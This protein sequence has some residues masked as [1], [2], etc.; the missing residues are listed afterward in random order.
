MRRSDIWTLLALAAM[1]GASFMFMRVVAPVLGWA[2]AANTRVMLGA[3]LI[4]SIMLWQRKPLKLRQDWRHFAVLGLINSALP[5]ALF[6][7]AA[8]Y[9]PAA[10][11]AVCNATAPLWGAL[12]GSL[13]FADRLSLPKVAGLLLG[14]SGVALTAG[15]GK[16]DL[17]TNAASAIGGTL[18]AALLYAVAGVY[19]KRFAGHIKPL[20]LGCGS[21]IAA[22]IWLLPLL[23]FYQPKIE[24]I[25]L[26]VVLCVLGAGLISTGL[27]YVLYFPLMQRIGPMRA[28]S[29]TF[30][31]PC[32]AVFFAYIFLGEALSLGS[33]AGCCIVL[34]GLFL[35]LKK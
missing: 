4:A 6:A 30:L 22:S 34:V 14:I 8:L 28:L 29:V 1:W 21:Q 33:L 35:V 27:P 11:S 24:L 20:A 26:K 25:D 12:L 16:I 10:Y 5:F 15:A 19:M 9:V 31:V 23:F 3:A 7:M 13:F 2:W 18:F 32:F 17:T